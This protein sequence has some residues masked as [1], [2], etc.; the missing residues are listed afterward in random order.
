MRGTWPTLMVVALLTLLMAGCDADPDD[1]A[2]PAGESSG[3]VLPPDGVSLSFGQLRYDEG[4]SRAQLRVVNESVDDLTVTGVGLDWPGYGDFVAD[5]ET[6]VEGGRTL[7]LRFELPEP[8]CE[9]TDAPV[10]GRLRVATPDGVRVLADELDESGT[11]YVTRIWQRRCDDLRVAQGV[12]LTYGDDW[13]SVGSGRR[14][15]IVGTVTVRRL[16]DDGPIT[17]R[18]IRGSVLLELHLPKPLVLDVGDRTATSTLEM[19]VPRCD[20]HALVDSSQ[21]FHFEPVFRFGDAETVQVFRI[22]PPPTREA[23]QQLLDEACLV[24]GT[25]Q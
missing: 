14:A 18:D 10:V 25:A 21:T 9:T 16:D 20:Q 3:D 19:Q 8:T 6:V 11:G 22:P 13:Q 7:D 5:Y 12:E 23:G 15:R 24:G 17:L 1:A 4:T 2:P